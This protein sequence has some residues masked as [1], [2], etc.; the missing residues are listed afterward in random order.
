VFFGVALLLIEVA[1]P[2]LLFLFFGMAA[3]VVALV[4]WLVAVPVWAQWILFSVL[5]VL[6]LFLLR[7][8]L[9]K[10]FVGDK[11]AAASIDDDVVGKGA[12]VVEAISPNRAGRVEFRGCTRTAES[13]EE[14]PVGTAVRICSKENITLVVR[15]G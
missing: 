3:L 12:T 4:T 10:I 2:G 1:L 9:K 7:K 5:S 8:T 15:R 6:S 14:I 11:N 13:D